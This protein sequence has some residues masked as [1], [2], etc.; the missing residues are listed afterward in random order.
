MPLVADSSYRFPRLLANGH[1]QTCFPAL[2]RRVASADYWRERIDTLD[3]DFLN[4]DWVRTGSQ[5]LAILA[6]GLEGDSR[7]HYIQ[8]MVHA[9]T[10]RNWDALAWN[11][12]GCGGEPNRLLRFTHSGATEDLNTVISHVVS[13]NDY[14][15]IALIGFS[16]GGNLIL[17]Y[18]G[19][20]GREVDSRIAAA[21]AFSV[22]CDLQASS[23]QLGRASNRIYMR[24]FLGSLHQ[25]I[26][27][28]MN[29]MPG[30]INDEGYREIRTFKQFD[31]RY[32]APIHGF[33]DAEDYWRKSSCRP[34]LPQI[35]VTTLLVNAR[36]DPFLAE[37]C[38]PVEEAKANSNLFLE[39]PKSGG[40]VG[41]MDFN[42]A[43]EYWS[44]RRA[45]EFLHTQTGR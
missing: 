38:F 31:D 24:H 2:T 4:L 42:S 23:T 14:T 10:R 32:T 22:P 37:T 8:G 36:N 17:K 26:R 11:A 5:R 6:H 29:L 27:I 7:R 33:R 44:E 25:K 15:R 13:S 40:H 39:M 19:E 41:F 3:G 1:L 12:R 45:V 28:L 18:L 34:F 35:H 9:L 20:R 30:K 43:K 21:V 16:L